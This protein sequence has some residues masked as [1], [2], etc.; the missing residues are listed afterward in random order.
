MRFRKSLLN[1]KPYQYQN[2]LEANQGFDFV[3]R[4]LDPQNAPSPLL[5]SDGRI[6]ETHRMAAEFLGKDGTNPA[7]FPMIINKGGKLV[8]LNRQEAMEHAKKTGEFIAFPTIDE[9][10]DFTQGYKPKAFRIFYGSK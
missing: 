9:A 4:I 7:A 6:K 5:S 3:Q 8:K 1:N 10:V 2:L